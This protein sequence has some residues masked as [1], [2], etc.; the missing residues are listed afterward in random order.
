MSI[1]QDTSKVNPLQIP[2]TFLPQDAEYPLPVSPHPWKQSA[3][4]LLS[5][6][7][8]SPAEF[9]SSPQG[10]LIVQGDKL[11]LK[12]CIPER[13][14]GGTRG[15]IKQDGKSRGVRRREA[16]ELAS[17]DWEW[18]DLNCVCRFVTL[19]TP[20]VC[21][22]DNKRVYKA[23][24]AVE[25]DLRKRYGFGLVSKE[26]GERS[27][28]LH[29][30]A[31]V[32]FPRGAS[33]PWNV[34][35]AG[36]SQ[37]KAG[38]GELAALWSRALGF[39]HDC[40]RV[41]VKEVGSVEGCRKYLNKYI[42]KT[43]YSA[44]NES[45]VPLQDSS[46]PGG[47]GSNGADES[48]GGSSSLFNAHNGTS[49]IDSTHNGN[50]WWYLVN[51]SMVP[52]AEKHQFELTA[53]GI[54]W[55]YKVRRVMR[56]LLLERRVRAQKRSL[57]VGGLVDK[58]L[59]EQ[60]YRDDWVN[61]EYFNRFGGFLDTQLRSWAKKDRQQVYLS[62]GKGFEVWAS[63]SEIYGTILASGVPFGITE[64]APDAEPVVH[65]FRRDCGVIV[66]KAGENMTSLYWPELAQ[67]LL[68]GQEWVQKNRNTTTRYAV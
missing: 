8:P 56:R 53:D 27:G 48:G 35:K 42:T 61:R 19:T 15:V 47:Q 1:P 66:K 14:G 39:P 49:E 16:S 13:I 29:Y 6:V 21:W 54:K 43:A 67:D 68:C 38:Q 64:I 30:H 3:L 2:E 36:P 59:A 7:P 26:R 25:K 45:E 46:A 4:K 65:P 58:V 31:L 57:L 9:F 23:L 17:W 55:A 22:G 62:G 50:R 60:K 12:R 20:P 18:I 28:M 11:R 5:S 40:I 41:E 10:Y 24:R 37:T 52:Y 32:C 33:H 34:Q 63:S 44:I 51:K